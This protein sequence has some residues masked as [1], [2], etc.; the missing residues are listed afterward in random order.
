MKIL[1][2]NAQ[3]WVQG[4]MDKV[5]LVQY[6]TLMQQGHTVA[7]FARR[8]PQNLVTPYRR[9]YPDEPDLQQY[10]IT[11]ASLLR[12]PRD[13]MVSLYNRGAAQKLSALLSDFQ[14]D[15]V[16]L[17]G[18]TRSLSASLYDVIHQRDLPMVQTH[19]YVK[20]ACPNGRL[21]KADKHYCHDMPCIT[22]NAMSCVRHRCQQGSLV[23]SALASLEFTLNRARY[24]DLPDLHLSPS[25]YL[26]DL[27][28]KSGVP[29]HKLALHP[30]FVDTHMFVPAEEPPGEYF[31]YFGRLSPEKGVMTLLE[32]FRSIPSHRLVLAG[33]G[34]LDQECRAFILKHRLNHI[35]CVGNQS[36]NA[37]VRLIQGARATLLP[38]VWGEI[39]GLS[40]LESFACGRPVIGSNVGAISELIDHEGNGLLVQPGDVTALSNAI[41]RLI[42]LPD[43]RI[44]EMGAQGLAM[45]Q[46]SYTL[47]HHMAQL[48]MHYASVLKGV[49]VS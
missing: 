3:D 29:S 28:L 21:L 1:I 42:A 25:R 4:G 27:L 20:L 31:L 5:A 47:E 17:H 19:H 48:Q 45:V 43:A 41:K 9:Y 13:M 18:V 6:E 32:A 36:G 26:A 15:L 23:K 24:R 12:L 10:R 22:G 39:F 33:S 8:H 30:N 38:A 40:I 34:P 37:L 46:Q 49:P 44:L 14:P 11:P 16:H 35:Q 2:V 7:F